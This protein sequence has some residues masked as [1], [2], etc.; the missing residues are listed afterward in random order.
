MKILAI[1]KKPRPF[2]PKSCEDMKP[3][4]VF[5]I[6]SI[7]KREYFLIMAQNKITLPLKAAIAIQD[8]DVEGVAGDTT[9]DLTLAIHEIHE[10]KIATL[11]KGLIGWTNVID[12]D[13]EKVPFNP[14]NIE[15]LDIT[16]INELSDEICGV[17]RPDD[18][19]NSDTQSSQENGT[20]TKNPESGTVTS[21][22]KTTS[23]GNETAKE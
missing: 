5:T 18:L 11:T 12:A 15:L 19:K 16:V 14:E 7:S 22:E 10:Q 13:G 9:V 23:P 3:K 8:K 17:I 6:R 21:A 2:T 1:S 20:K 4:P